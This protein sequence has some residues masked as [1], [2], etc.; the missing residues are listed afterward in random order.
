[1]QGLHEEL[2]VSENLRKEVQG[3]VERATD[4]LY[5]R[6]RDNGSWADRLSSSAI[7]TPLAVLALARAGRDTYREEIAAGL[8][9]LREHQREDGG[10]SLA[11]ADPPS[12][13]SVT[14]FAV[15]AFEM[16]DRDGS[17]RCIDR[18]MD[19]IA[20]QGGESV[21][22]P[23]VRTW[24]ELV[25]VVWALEGLRDMTQQPAQPIEVMLLPSRMRNRASIALP[26]VIGLGIGQSR[27]LPAGVI[28]RA[29]RRLAEPRGLAWLRS[30]M[31]RNG[32]IEECPL[33]AAIVFMGLRTAG[34]DIGADIQ[35]GCIE[36]L[37]STRRADG[38]WAIDRDLEIAVTAYAVLALAECGVITDEPRL[39]HTK[40]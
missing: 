19:F 21:I 16:L 10:W 20:S 8:A 30:V 12:D 28:R 6:Q 33:M 15:A 27:V 29:A 13:G 1:M 17:Q 26:G 36:Y 39:R 35:S 14:A 9:W 24:R 37:L 2:V 31:G 18:A 4:Y 38:S 11:D 32:G 5:R 25:S 22:F 3:A 34:A 7:P 40:D 23:N